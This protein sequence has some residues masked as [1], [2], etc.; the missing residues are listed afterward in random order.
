M[1]EVPN[2]QVDRTPQ[3]VEV[4]PTLSSA[5]VRNTRADTMGSWMEQPWWWRQRLSKPQT[6]GASTHQVASWLLGNDS[7][8]KGAVCH[9]D[10]NWHTYSR[11]GFASP[12][13][14][15]SASRTTQPLKSI[16]SFDIGSCITLHWTEG[17]IIQ[18]KGC[19]MTIGVTS[20]IT[21]STNQKLLA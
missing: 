4:S 17:P 9:L 14:R 5:D 10:W 18:Q 8:L 3:P 1:G 6:A 15:A 16:W 11:Y 2:N 21:Y 12:A 20:P 13:C 19:R 7:T